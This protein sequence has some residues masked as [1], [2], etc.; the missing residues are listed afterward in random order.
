MMLRRP[1]ITDPWQTLG[2]SDIPFEDMVKLDFTYVMNWNL[3]EDFKLLIKNGRSGDSRPGRVLRARGAAPLA[4][5]RV[6]RC[7]SRRI[8]VTPVG[9]W[10][11]QS[12][13]SAVPRPGSIRCA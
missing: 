13:T 1:G 3:S 8:D 10:L 6:R 7:L 4:R 2:R 11:T 12:K 5:A 9:Y